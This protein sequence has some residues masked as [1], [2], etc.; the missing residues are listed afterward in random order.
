MNNLPTKQNG[1]DLVPV[2][3]VQAME[4][5]KMLASSNLVPKAYQGKPED[6]YLAI[7]MGRTLGLNPFSSLKGICVINGVPCVWG[8]ILLSLVIPYFEDAM[9]EEFD[10]TTFTASCTIKRKGWATPMTKT[11]S[12]EDA[13][14]AK[15]D[16]KQTWQQFPKQMLQNRARAHC[17]RAMFADILNGVQSVEEVMDY[18]VVDVN[19]SASAYTP[20]FNEP[21]NIEN[22]TNNKSISELFNSYSSKANVPATNETPSFKEPAKPSKKDKVLAKIKTF[23]TETTSEESVVANS[24]TTPSE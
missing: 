7:S 14:R 6:I 3:F 13:Q 17:I 24:T 23:E 11:F 16:T 20:S 19:N 10:E 18:D 8:D 21:M 9:K 12:W 5:S 2:D 15:L 1:F 4:M 22:N